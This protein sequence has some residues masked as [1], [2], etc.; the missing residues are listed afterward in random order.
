MILKRFS[1]FENKLQKMDKLLE[2]DPELA[3]FVSE[4]EQTER[5]KK[6]TYK[7]TND[8]WDLCVSNPNVSRFDSKTESCLANCVER[9]I[10]SSTFILNEFSKKQTS[11]GL[12]G[13]SSFDD[14]D[15]LLEDKPFSSDSSSSSSSS[16]GEKRVVLN[17]G[18]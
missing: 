1:R 2:G 8:C 10:D 11:S 3:R 18:D 14:P 5:L 4:L 13:S 6:T 7:L 16:S 9:F 17:S 15:I 12:G